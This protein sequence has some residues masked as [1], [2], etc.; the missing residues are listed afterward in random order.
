M[1]AHVHRVCA[2]HGSHVALTA[3]PA[4]EQL[5]EVEDAYEAEKKKLKA[6]QAE[7]AKLSGAF[8]DA[9]LEL[10]RQ[11]TVVAEAR[12]A[13]LGREASPHALPLHHA[14]NPQHHH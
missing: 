7:G 1:C 9:C 2:A 10:N 8:S 11:E 12:Q 14:R 6:L 3:S 13:T 5:K 4:C